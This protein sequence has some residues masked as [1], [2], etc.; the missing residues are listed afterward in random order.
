MLLTWGTHADKIVKQKRAM[1]IVNLE[2][3]TAHTEPLLINILA[4]TNGLIQI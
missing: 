4:Q 2:R 1:R 3:Q